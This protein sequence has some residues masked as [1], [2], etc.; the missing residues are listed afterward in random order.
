MPIS[1]D[2]WAPLPGR[3]TLVAGGTHH[4]MTR[5]EDDWWRPAHPLPAELCRSGVDYGYLLDD[6][7]T[8]RPDPRSRYQPEGVHGLSR[9]F[10]PAGHAW[11][12]Q[13]WG[14]RQLA[15]GAVYE[16]HV[17]T[18]AGV[19]GRSGT[20]DSAI[21]H[22]DHLVD[23]GIDFVELMPVN[24]F[25]GEHGWGYDGVGWYAVH[26]AYG[27]PEAYLRF[28]DACHQR[29]LAVIQD[30]VHNHLGPSGNY[31]TQFAPYLKPAATPWGDAINID[32]P[33]SDE[34]RAHILDNA[35]M[36]LRDYHVDGLRLDAVHALVDTHAMHILEELAGHVEALSAELGRPLTLIAESDRNDP[37]FV[38]APEAGGHGLTAQ[39]NDDFHHALVANLT[40]DVSGYY[41]DFGDLEALAKVCR[42]GFFH[43]GVRSSFRGRRHGRP[44]DITRT[45]A[46]RFVVCQDNH[47]QIGNRADGRRLASMVSTD[48]VAI[49]AALT[50]LGPMTPM[51]FQGEEWA[52]STPFAF[53]TSHPEPELAEA[54]REGRKAEFAEMAWDQ[55]RILDPQDEATFSQSMLI[56][57]ELGD[58]PHA[59][60]LELN[61]QLLRIRRTVP[62]FADPRFTSVQVDHA[63][64]DEPRWF[65]LDRG[66]R[67]SVVVN[68]GEDEAS[69]PIPG[70]GWTV[71]LGRHADLDEAS[72]VLRLGGHGLAVL[73]RG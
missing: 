12:D 9:T 70:E 17:G 63:G 71:L 68:F 61:T 52:A 32:G 23:L 40:G 31:L 3:V 55:S 13:R 5:G 64:E 41:A 33:C 60:V 37:R 62:G 50:L 16:L 43:D 30:V 58:Q 45:Q 21:E 1:Y 36:W 25:N 10:D 6:E 15:G 22:L 20:L 28:V 67:S 14:G 47:D 44:I 72:S 46:W 8:P 39:W 54:V 2:I 34:V 11:N 48:Q 59:E 7:T 26:H 65:R 18:F 51:V 73:H 27:G 24:A 29:G 35:T 42:R 19:D 53:F 4:P 66:D 56:W 38:T 57:D 49:A 69:V